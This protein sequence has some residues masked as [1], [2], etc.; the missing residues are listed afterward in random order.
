MKE[1][2]L[3][4]R[5]RIILAGILMVAVP[6]LSLAAF[7]KF[8]VTSALEG[9]IIKETEWFSKIAA[10]QIE[11][12][13]RSDIR[14]GR[15][16]VTRPLILA[17]VKK[18]DRTEMTS[19]LKMLIGDFQSLERAF[20][21]SP[22]GVLLADYPVD[23]GVHGKDFSDRDWYKGVSKNWEPYVSEFYMRMAAPK[24]YLFAVAIPMR[25]GGEIAGVL[26]L[27]PKA[28]Y[29]KDVLSGVEI[30]KGHI[31]MVDKKGHLIHHPDY[32][33]D[34]IVDFSGVPVVQKVM[35]GEEG[36]EEILDPK[37]NEPVFSSYRPV[38]EWGWGVIVDK[39][40]NVVLEPI[41]KISL[42]LFVVT[43]FMLVAGG[44]IA[45]RG[46]D[47]LIAT[48]RLTEKLSKEEYFQKIYNDFL[49][50]L[51]RQYPNI[52]E[53]CDATLRKFSEHALMNAAVFYVF[54]DGSLKAYST[55]AVER[56]LN[57][58]SFCSESVMQKKM[59]RIRDIPGDTYLRVGTG[60]GDFLPKEIIAMPLLFRDEVMAVLELA[61]INGFSEDGLKIIEQ[62]APQLAIGINTVKAHAVQRVLS[63]EL[64][65]SNEELQSM[66]E[67]L[68]S[69]N[70]EA[71]AMNEEL[72]SQQKELSE[73]NVRLMEISRAKSDF[74]ANM[75]HELRTPL[76]SIL[77][78]SEILQDG[79]YGRL[80]EK[81]EEYVRT[82]YGSG[83]HL[84]EL[85]NDVLD[86]SKVES[87]KMELEL[88]RVGV[89]A[90]LEAS[91]TMLKEKAMKHGIDLCIELE[92]EAD[93]EIE[94]DER[95]LKQI[96]FNLLSNAVKFTP[97]GGRVRVRARRVQK[98]ESAEAQEQET[99]ELPD[100]CTTEL[101]D[102]FIEISVVDTGIGIK[103]EDIPKLFKEFCQL[104]SPYTK[105]YQG[106][107]LGLALTKRLVE[108]HGGMIWVE[109][110]F[111]KGSRFSFYIPIKQSGKQAP[112][113]D[114]KISITL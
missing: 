98:R 89:R 110:E 105:Q 60:I 109:S 20:I 76:N 7:V 74:L 59:L 104:E 36:I 82:I 13:L 54:E 63:E 65:K 92:P 90:L 35:R 58:S 24:R 3:R 15:A 5:W 1:W 55:F 46:A 19:H 39:P 111:G 61:S 86:L 107:G 83:R 79:L 16:F 108:L 85:I 81:Q 42:W 22:K 73:A 37:D 2:L 72:Q 10:N 23:P 48:Q 87:G 27:Q 88:E 112:Q 64:H 40:V 106:A 96:M 113:H 68:Q 78:F 31:Y 32:E 51:N 75:S 94:A 99:S 33:L 91:M 100:F 34:R 114:A 30:G 6:L 56:P 11:E 103:Q 9:R 44:F 69:M 84:L 8:S 18:L 25:A 52:G 102:D 70:E 53:L 62:V 95:K 67:E 29:I 45:Y 47:L 80:N 71:Q 41:R 101:N 12:R 43:G 97:E 26:V 28:D 17:A 14:V 21:A 49:T 38:K 66:N 50:L 4:K 57:L 93:I 77:G